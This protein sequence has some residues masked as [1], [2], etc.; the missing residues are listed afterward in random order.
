M[1]GFFLSTL[2]VAIAPLGRTGCGNKS[3]QP[4]P[5]PPA[6]AQEPES[7]EQTSESPSEH[8]ASEHPSEHPE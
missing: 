6:A 2:I 4:E 7:E 1:R 3:E 5:A 8:P